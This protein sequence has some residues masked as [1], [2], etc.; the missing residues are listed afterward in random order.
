MSLLIA[1]NYPGDDTFVTR[2]VRVTGSA[3]N[4]DTRDLRVR[5]QTSIADSRELRITGQIGPITYIGSL[6]SATASGSATS[7]TLAAPFVTAGMH[8]IL[9]IT[10]SSGGN[11]VGASDPRGNI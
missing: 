10:H 5:G 1:L 6:G 7:L 9:L 3:L 2:D 8:V 11:V 4:S